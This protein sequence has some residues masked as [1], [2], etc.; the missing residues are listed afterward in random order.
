MCAGVVGT[1]ARSRTAAIRAAGTLARRTRSER[2]F[3]RVRRSSRAS[4]RDRRTRFGSNSRQHDAPMSEPKPFLQHGARDRGRGQAR[5]AGVEHR[6][7]DPGHRQRR[8]RDLLAVEVVGATGRREHVDVV[9]DQVLALARG[10]AAAADR[11]PEAGQHERARERA[12][13]V[14][15]AVEQRFRRLQQGPRRR[16]PAARTERAGTRAEQMVR[17]QPVGLRRRPAERIAQT[18]ANHPRRRAGQHLEIHEDRPRRRGRQRL[19]V[20][21]DGDR[22]VHRRVAVHRRR[23][24]EDHIRLAVLRR[25]VLAQVVDGPGA[26]RD[27]RVGRSAR[28]PERAT[29]AASACGGASST[30]GRI[31]PSEASARSTR[32][33]STARVVGSLTTASRRPSPSGATSSA[34]MPA[35][36]RS[37][38]RPRPARRSAD[39]GPGRGNRRAAVGRARSR[40]ASR[41]SRCSGSRR[42]AG[43]AAISG[44]GRRRR[45]CRG[46]GRETIPWSGRTRRRT[47]PSRW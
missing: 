3:Q 47:P 23:R 15:I 45:G 25:R 42:T 4:R 12:H 20:T 46:S 21:V 40:S 1:P 11:H 38:R 34:S 37:M 31:V 43:H 6:V 32:A 28:A 2:S 27:E 24:G 29:V 16:P 8:H 19:L 41:P 39:R 10:V 26:D 7:L 33:P 35:R 44:P 14:E 22:G 5:R 17:Q 13:R 18:G 30:T 9:T 36:L